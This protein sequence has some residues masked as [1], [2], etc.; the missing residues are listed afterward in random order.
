M[1]ANSDQLVCDWDG[2]S[3][4]FAG[5]SNLRRHV[6]DNHTPEVTVR[7]NEETYSVERDLLGFH[8]VM[9][10]KTLKTTSTF[11][12]HIAN[13]HNGTTS[14]FSLNK[15]TEK[16]KRSFSTAPTIKVTKVYDKN[17]IQQAINLSKE[18][19]VLSKEIA[20][21]AAAGFL[22][23]EIA[24]QQK[25]LLLTDLLNLQPIAVETP[26]KNYYLLGDG[27]TITELS[28]NQPSAS[29]TVPQLKVPTTHSRVTQ[30]SLLR[31]LIA[32]SGISN[33]LVNEVYVEMDENI[34][35]VANKDWVFSPQSKYAVSQLFAGC[36]LL[37]GTK[38]LL[39]NCIESYGRKSGN[40]AHAERYSISDRETSIP[41][42]NDRYD[43]VCVRLMNKDN[44]LKLVIGT[45]SCNLLVTSSCTINENPVVCVG[46]STDSFKPS[47][48]TQIFLNKT[49]VDKSLMLLSDNDCHQLY[50]HDQMEQLKQIR[51]KFYRE[52]TY[53][54]CRC[55][56]DFTKGH[57]YQPCS[58][59][60]LLNSSST[61]EESQARKAS[62]IF[63]K[64]AMQVINS[65]NCSKQ[66]AVL[67]KSA[68]KW[69]DNKNGDIATK[70]QEMKQLF[71]EDTSIVIIGN[72]KLDEQ[73]KQLA[74]L[75][76]TPIQKANEVVKSR[77][78]QKL[79][80]N[81]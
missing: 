56:S 11:K 10:N 5:I 54:K 18:S 46:P 33:I 52:E 59:W 21:V 26:N 37:D 42:H 22:D 70:V 64:I 68:L 20:T 41:A 76:V 63:N 7:I 3:S 55:A 69:F 28:A 23:A 73:L 74:K 44:S 16:R 19:S 13:A 67:D 8:C 29:F 31:H 58:I 47:N 49:S 1:S 32:S 72:S 43:S 75:L 35:N 40:D 65:S 36:I 48:Q 34:S 81:P 12:V 50:P 66:T 51:S 60:T 24:E 78:A 57:I 25:A 61:K 62:E 77:L 4:S 9:C 71:G 53:S 27:C 80:N 39:I 6:Y 2:C 15:L 14:N 30:Q 38:A 17:E 45:F 79:F